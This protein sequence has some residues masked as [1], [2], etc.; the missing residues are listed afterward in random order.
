M[1]TQPSFKQTLKNEIGIAL[2]LCI[3]VTPI[4]AAT[5]TTASLSL[6][7]VHAVILTCCIALCS[8]ALVRYIPRPSRFS[9]LFHIAMRFIAISISTALALPVISIIT[10][11]PLQVLA[12]RPLFAALIPVVSA[13]VILTLTQTI[14][15]EREKSLLAQMAQ[16]RAVWQALTAQI[17][18]HFLFNCLNG[19][20]Q[21]VETDPARAQE[22]IRHLAALYRGVLAASEQKNVPL[23]NEIELTTDYLQLQQMRYLDRLRYTI[24]VSP[25]VHPTLFPATLL[26]TLV[27]NSVKHGIEKC[28]DGGPIIVQITR[29]QN[30]LIAMVQNPIPRQT[31]APST[32]QGYGTNSIRQRLLLLF[33]DNARYQLA[34]D[35]H[36]ATAIIELPVQPL[37]REKAND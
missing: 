3:L 8:A 24:D 18:P 15:Q 27:E 16:T 36:T 4:V 9:L 5:N 35:N 12:T 22:N 14:R 13:Y 32:K 31:G 25:N 19:L 20:E 34:L 1:E 6:I 28:A 7:L 2:L 23:E 21:L 11:I 10:S 29:R 17:R 26:L 33:G 37:V 30:Q